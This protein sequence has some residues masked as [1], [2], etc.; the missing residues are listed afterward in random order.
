MLLFD[1]V[2]D[3][4]QDHADPCQEH[5]EIEEEEASDNRESSPENPVGLVSVAK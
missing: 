3:G 2:D 4:Q 1:V 5:A